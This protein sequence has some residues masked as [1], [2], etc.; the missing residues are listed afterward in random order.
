VTLVFILFFFLYFLFLGLL[1]YAWNRGL[2]NLTI[3]QSSGQ[4]NVSIVIA[5]RNECQT[6]GTLLEK[7]RLQT[8]TNF[9]VI[10]VDDHSTDGTAEV[11]RY[12][13]DQD[14]RF[15]IMRSSG[16]GKKAA[17]T[18]GIKFSKEEIVVTTD[19]DCWVEAQWLQSMIAPFRDKETKFVFGGVKIEGQTFFSKLQSHEFL[20]LIGTAA[21]TLWWGFPTMCNGANLA[22]RKSV[23]L[24]VGGYENNFHIPSGDDE[25]LMHKIHHRY[26]DGVL[27]IP[28]QKAIVRTSAVG[29][30]EFIHQRIRWAGKWSHNLSMLNIM[31]AMAIFLFQASI[32]LLPAATVV[33]FIDPYLAAVLVLA[34]GVVECILL[35]KVARFSA[36]TWSWTAFLT[37]QIV[38]PLY[39]VFIAVISGSVSFDWK[40]RTLKSFTVSTV[41][42]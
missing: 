12:F 20:S 23:F 11:V 8:H 19:A 42:K 18:T 28:D 7:I 33:G 17:L 27:F 22:F 24:E 9:K 1:I 36:I 30:R 25:F 37:L 14:P 26:P 32:I 21:G 41:K 4:P 3:P 15:S 13:G 10:I 39:A 31:L 5:A 38:Y 34:K 40:G 2:T 16:E 35:R 29:P 6:I